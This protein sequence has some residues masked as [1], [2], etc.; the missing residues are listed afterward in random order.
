[1]FQ[2]TSIFCLIR[3]ITL[4]TQRGAMIWNVDPRL[5]LSV[6]LSSPVGQMFND[7]FLY[8]QET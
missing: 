1:L 5:Q 7:T 2:D 6:S 3:I 8:N 4:M